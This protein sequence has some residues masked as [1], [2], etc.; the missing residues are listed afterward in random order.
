MNK[1]IFLVF[2]VSLF[3]LV[4]FFSSESFFEQGCFLNQS[5]FVF[6]NVSFTFV[7]DKLQYSFDLVSASDVVIPDGVFY[8]NFGFPGEFS[9]PIFK[10]DL[11]LSEL[12]IEKGVNTFSGYV[13]LPKISFGNNLLVN[14][15]FYSAHSKIVDSSFSRISLVSAKFSESS[16]LIYFSNNSLSYDLPM[17][18][19]YSISDSSLDLNILV[20]NPAAPISSPVSIKIF[21]Y[22]D[23][24]LKN[25]LFEKSEIFNLSDELN[26]VNFSFSEFPSNSFVVVGEL[27]NGSNFFIPVLMDEVIVDFFGLAGFPFISGQPIYSFVCFSNSGYLDFS[28]NASYDYLDFFEVSNY[29]FFENDSYFYLIQENKRGIDNLELCFDSP[30]FYSCKNYSTSDSSF[31][32]SSSLNPNYD[33]DFSFSE[34]SVFFDFNSSSKI[35]K[36]YSDY[37]ELK[38]HSVSMVIL[39]SFNNIVFSKNDFYISNSIY[40]PLN[41]NTGKYSVVLS[42]SDFDEEINFD[43]FIRPISASDNSFSLENSLY[44]IVLIIGIVIILVG[45]VLHF[46]KKNSYS[47]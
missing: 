28:L 31:S 12:S 30:N 2:I 40:F 37:S 18:P 6:R 14:I 33:S 8:I 23:Y 46:S 25:P 7:D 20:V 1:N 22:Y 26:F 11:I 17:F 5:D 15:S 3:F 47:Y 24:K 36:I 34:F 42:S 43:F 45:V 39:D 41:L 35:L 21:D 4:P 29:H 27:E 32:D 44:L 38:N 10:K 13:V 9:T 16:D 19:A